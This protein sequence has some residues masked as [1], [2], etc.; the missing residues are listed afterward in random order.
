MFALTLLVAVPMSGCSGTE[1]PKVATVAPGDMPES[2]EW[3]GV[4]FDR[5]YG[6]FHLVQEGK[7]VNG[8]WERPQKDKWGELHGEV[9]GNVL[10]FTWTEYTR[11]AIG[12]NAQRSGKGYFVY[13][14]PPGE[15]VDDK[16]VGEIGK[17]QDE[18]GKKI[19][20]VKQRNTPVDPS[21]IGGTA[22]GDFSGGDWDKSGGDGGDPEPPSP[23]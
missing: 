14:R 11:N 18:V 5:W 1:A 10:R 21:S 19:D 6:N 12:A 22:P 4:Y 23:P 17:G 2:A 20:T 3:T 15:N 7:A 16:M 9:T 13:S 8:K